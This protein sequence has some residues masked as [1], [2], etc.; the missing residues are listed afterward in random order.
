MKEESLRQGSMW[1]ISGQG[2]S[3][4]AR[5]VY[6]VLIVRS[7]GSGE[8][9]AFA[10]VAALVA[11]LSQFSTLGM[12]MIL[13][14]NISRDR[15]SFARTWGQSLTVLAV[16]FAG[17]LGAAMLA[18]HFLLRPEL[19][20]LVPWIVLS[21][22]L[23]GKLVQLAGRAFQGAGQ[24]RWTAR[25]TALMNLCRTAA[26]G[27]VWGWAR[28]EH[29]QLT[30]Y[31]WVHVYWIATLAV[32]AVA[33]WVV[34]GQLGWPQFERIGCGDLTEGLSFSLSSSSIS[35]Y[36]DI[37]KT[38]L[39]SLGAA[40]VTG[41]YTA[42]YR[43]VDAATTPIFSVYAAA[44][45][46]FF[47]AGEK[48]VQQ[49]AAFS[50]KTIAKTLPYAVLASAAMWLGAPLLPLV[51]GASFRES[52]AA[53]RWLS[54]L[55]VLRALHYGWG[56]AITG[57]ASQWNRTATQFAAALLN[58]VLDVALIPRWSWRGA[59]AASLA[60]DGALALFSYLVLQRLLQREAAAQSVGG[61]EPATESSRSRNA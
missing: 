59:A 29:T 47:R 17:L 7:L 24:L 1:M 53:L 30:A 39:I 23:L 51:F 12:E 8:Y 3:A 40:S 43:V 26:A 10:G 48:G 60:T 35:I 61:A 41:I 16:G 46:R 37:D 38:F 5:A 20:T 15:T 45:P 4:A 52:V 21:D 31:F 57:S 42:A 14:R 34:T 33:A 2:F 36:N 13:V 19:R 58:V 27:A 25:L 9:G 11:V 54:L 49:A 28:A 50:R 22:G 56:T 6:L 44:T 55:P 18:A 32:A